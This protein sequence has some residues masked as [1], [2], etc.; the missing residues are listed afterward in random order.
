MSTIYVKLLGGLGNQLFQYATG[1]ALA[2]RHR[3]E[4]KLDLSFFETYEL[5]RYEL[6]VYPIHAQIAGSEELDRLREFGPPQPSG[7]LRRLFGNRNAGPARFYVESSPYFDGQLKELPPPLHIEGYWQSEKYFLDIRRRLI[8]ELTPS[9]P[10]EPENQEMFSLA[11]KTDSISLHIR[12]GDYVSNDCVNRVHGVLP[13]DY[14]HQALALL[15]TRVPDPHVFVFSDDIEWAKKNLRLDVPIEYVTANGE[16][17]A[18]R[19]IQLQSTC[20]HHITANSSFSW[21]GAWLNPR[22]G[23]TVV[24]PKRWLN[25]VAGDDSRDRVPETWLRV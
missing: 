11:E 14:Y 5:R 1:R 21:W 3:A 13:L 10:I 6:S 15:K 9:L 17:R 7:L 20:K 8:K 18:F 25:E 4:L 22:A 12:R 24:G 2:L 23:K 19:D 16:Q